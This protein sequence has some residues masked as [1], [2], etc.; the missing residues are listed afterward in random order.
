MNV[1]G[2]VGTTICDVAY[3]CRYDNISDVVYI[4]PESFDRNSTTQMAEEIG[5][6]NKVMAY[7]VIW[8]IYG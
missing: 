5:K 4:K 7:I 3:I 8:P 2:Y 1:Y 6:L